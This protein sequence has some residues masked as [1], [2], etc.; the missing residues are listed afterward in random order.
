MRVVQSLWSANQPDPFRFKAGWF[1]PEYHLMAWAL[2]CLQLRQFYDDVVLYTDSQGARVLIDQL[3]LP[4]TEVVCDLDKINSY[5]PELWAAGK[6]YTYRQQQAPFI[7][8][9]GD[10]FIWKA[11]D[12]A[13][14][15]ADLIA[16]N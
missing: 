11:F 13:L 1:A 8:V 9:D 16:Q 10:V 15:N 7:H 12:E 4:Y 3:Q 5:H 2:S 6:I 14:L